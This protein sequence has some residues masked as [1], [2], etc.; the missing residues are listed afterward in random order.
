M[1]I[2][3]SGLFVAVLITTV[4]GAV[5]VP[6]DARFNVFFGV[7]K[8]LQ[9]T[10]SK[11]YTLT[12]FVLIGLWMYGLSMIASSQNEGTGWLGAAIMAFFLLVEFFSM[13]R[14][15]PRRQT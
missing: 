9:M 5:V 8:P 3:L 14:R 1:K 4:W 11:S 13:N 7:P 6:P 12:V 15:V 10:M 2:I